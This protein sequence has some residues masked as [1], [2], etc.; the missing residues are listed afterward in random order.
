[1]FSSHLISDNREFMA[2]ILASIGD[3][4]VVTDLTGKIIFMNSLAEEITGRGNAWAV[5]RDFDK[6]FSLYNIDKDEPE[7]SPIFRAIENKSA[8]GLHAGTVL[9][10]RDG[11]WK[12]LSASSS[13]I[14]QSGGGYCG[15]VVVFRDITR[16][17]TLEQKCQNEE[18]N[19]RTIFNAAPVGMLILDTPTLI[20]QINETA[21]KLIGRER[22]E[23]IGKSFGNGFCCKGSAGSEQGCGYGSLC[24]NCELRRSIALAFEGLTISGIEYEQCFGNA[25]EEKTYWFR[26]SVTP[27]VVGA[28]TKVVVALVDVTVRKRQE[29]AITQSRNFYLRIFE[30]FPTIIWRSDFDQNF[31]YINRSWY[32]LT[33]Q[34]LEQ[35]MGHGWLER[36]HP[37]DKKN[38]FGNHDPQQQGDLQD[39]EIRVLHWS[40]QYRWLY[41][42]NRLFYN[43]EGI[44]EGYIGMGFDITDRKRAEEELSKYRLLSEKA[45]DIIVFVD[46]DGKIVEANEAAVKAYG[47]SRKQLLRL[48]IADLRGKGNEALIRRQMSEAKMS[49]TVFETV[50][51]RKDGTSFPVE[52]SSQGAAIGGKQVIVSIIRDISERK[53]AEQELK[54]AKE[55]AEAA[56]KAKS[57]FLANMSHEIRTP[58]NGITGMIDLTL[59]SAL[60]PEQRENL[61]T[62]KSCAKSLVLLINDILDFSKLEAGKLVIENISFELGSFVDELMKTHMPGAARKGLALLS[63][64]SSDVPRLVSGDPNRLRQVLNNLVDNGI[65]FSEKGKV[66]LSVAVANLTGQDVDLIFS[67]TDTGIG[68]AAK[69]MG[70]LFKTFSQVDGSVTRHFGGTGLGLVIS[71]RLVEMMGGKIRVTSEKGSGS[72]FS[73]MVRLTIATAA[74]TP[75]Q[76]DLSRLRASV[77]M[78][79]LLVE[80]DLISRTVITRLL[81]ALGHRVDETGNGI[82]ALVRLE[83]K[84][85]DIILM[86]IQMPKLDGI[87][88][89]A[90][91]RAAEAN[92]HRHVPIIAITA[93]ALSGDRERCLAVGMDEYIAKPVQMDTLFQKLEEFSPAR[94]NRSSPAGS[95]RIDE[96]GDITF[97]TSQKD[98]SEAEVAAAFGSLADFLRQM[99]AAAQTVDIERIEEI[100]HHIK[101]LATQIDAEDLKKEAFKTEL[102]TRRGNLPEAVEHIARI[103]R[104]LDIYQKSRIIS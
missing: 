42:V 84:D 96:T 92:Q 61:S 10:A 19:L 59:L 29:I 60:N 62:A 50:H 82:E 20:S 27:I 22:G 104:I 95:L 8:I 44:A 35:A 69:D 99:S 38:C 43:L 64:V 86:D 37:D 58:I 71:K 52:V 41:C 83:Q 72:T 9:A 17:R 74:K 88:T 97:R 73:F 15:V 55:E 2:G 91:I 101:E 40:G 32:E 36:V 85:Y 81:K 80:D 33:R 28:D 11:S 3:G 7:P 75:A 31:E 5:G 12:Y 39:R 89:T 26:A 16:F 53:L 25:G 68:I 66:T 21:L 76:P 57:E 87:E 46:R 65:K 54:R 48:S 90:R 45:R 24:Q 56:Y 49:D 23:V 30:S 47:Y 93:H 102:A 100:A 6:V 79:I 51:Y 1:M 94:R 18:A 14:E 4:V 70:K 63:Q 13:P 34:P 77:P 98:P 67:V 78:N 103:Q